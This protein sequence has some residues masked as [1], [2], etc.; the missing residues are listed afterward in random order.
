[1]HSIEFR[2]IASEFQQNKVGSTRTEVKPVFNEIRTSKYYNVLLISGIINKPL[3]IAMLRN[4]TLFKKYLPE[5][6]ITEEEK[7]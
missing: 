1:M 2:K 7:Q 6:Y 5:V 3:L 4:D